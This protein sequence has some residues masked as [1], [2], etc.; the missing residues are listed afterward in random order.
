VGLLDRT[1]TLL[2]QIGK[3]RMGR[4]RHAR[5]ELRRCL[6]EAMESRQLLSAAP[7]VVGAVYIEEDLGS[8]AHGDTFQLTFEGGA[9]GTELARLTISTDQ[10]TPGFSIGDVFFDTDTGSLGADDSFPFMLLTLETADP[11]ASVSATVADGGLELVL[12]FNGFRAGDRLTFQIDVDEVEYLDAAETDLELVNEGFDPITSGIEFQGSLMRAEFTAEHYYEVQAEGQFWNRY[13]DRFAGS[14]LQLPSDDANG[15]RDRSTGAIGTAQQQPLPISLAGTVYLDNDL[16]LVQGSGEMGLSGVTLELWQLQGERYQPTGETTVTDAEG[17]YRFGPELGL[18]PGTYQ[19]REVQPEGLFSVGASPGQVLGE[20]VGSVVVGQPDVLTEIHLPLGDLHA[21][22]LDFAEADPAEVS[23]WVYHDR[24]NNGL[25]DDGEEGISG[26]SLQIEPLDTIAAQA[27][28][29]VVTDAGGAYAATGLAPGEYRVVEIEQPQGFL[30]GLDAAGTVRGLVVGAAVNPGDAIHD[31]TLRGGDRGVEY[32]FGELVPASISG[33]VRLADRDGD[34][35]GDDDQTLPLADVRIQL[36]EMSDRLVAETVTDTLG[37]YRFAGLR[38][39]IYRVVEFTPEGLI[40]GAEH[41]GTVDGVAVGVAS[42]DGV[43]EDI[44]LHS[45]DRGVD[46]DFCEL[47]PASL[48]GHVYHD[49]NDD[50]LRG[51]GEEGLSGAVVQLL[52]DQGGIVATQLTDEAGYYEFTDLHAGVYDVSELQPDGW[53][54]GQDHAGTVNG[55]P[56][57]EV[58]IDGDRIDRVWLRWG[59]EAEDYDFGELQMASISGNV[60]LSTPAGDCYGPDG[61]LPPLSGVQVDL[62]NEQGALLRTEYTNEDGDY[63]FPDLRPGNYTIVE[64][65]PAEVI[66]GAELIGTIDGVTVGQVTGNDRIGEIVITSGQHALDYDFCEHAPASLAGFVY[67]DRDNDGR[68]ES[69]DPPIA[70]VVVQLWDDQGHLVAETLTDGAGEF[71]FAGLAAGAYTLREIQPEGYRD[72]TDSAGRVGTQTVGSAENPGDAIDGILLQWGDDGVDYA[73]AEWISSSIEGFV[74]EDRDQDCQ[75]DADEAAI[76]NVLIELFDDQGQRLA[77]TR[78]DADGHY[79]FDD[80]APGTYALAERQPD[81]Y[82]HGCQ[83]AGTGG[84]EDALEDA[85][86]DILMLSGER[87]REYNFGEIPPVSLSGYVFQDGAPLVSSDGRL[88]ANARTLRDGLRTDDDLPIAGVTIE[89]RDGTTGQPLSRAMVLPGSYGPGPIQAITDSEGHYAFS[90]LRPGNYAVFEVQPAGFFDGNDT[91][92]TFAAYAFNDEASL[93]SPA[94]AQLMVDHHF[95]AIVGIRIPVGERSQENNFSEI[96]L[97]IQTPRVPPP[98]PPEPARLPDPL[99]RDFVPPPPKAP[100]LT[101]VL[102]KPAYFRLVGVGGAIEF[103]WHLSV[104]DAGTPRGPAQTAVRPSVWRLT[105]FLEPADWHTRPMDQGRWLLRHGLGD[106]ARVA[107]YQFGTED[108]LPIVA[109][110]NGDGFDELGIYLEGLWYVDLNGNGVWDDEDLWALL[111]TE[112]DLPVTG[113]WNGDGKDDI[114][115]FGPAWEG[116]PRALS[117]ES[118]LPDLRNQR[119]DTEK[120]KNV[121]PEPDEATN[122]ARVLRHTP[123]GSAR[124]D[125]ID[126]VFQYGGGEEIPVSGDWSGDGIKNIGIFHNGSWR[127]DIDGDGRWSEGDRQVEFGKAADLPVVGDFNG[128]GIDDLAVFRDG[129]WIVDINGNG[130]FD[131]H[132]LVFAHGQP[133]DLPIAGDWNADGTDD[134]GVYRQP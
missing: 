131:A 34:C 98:D 7:L 71:A 84:G 29:T 95:D 74:Y 108:G 132:D 5:G 32:N 75:R 55:V 88:P 10:N 91:L 60:H 61:T 77:E 94:A 85:I 46:Y 27:V 53:I 133:G 122:R 1:R 12:D 51:T 37:R 76:A 107:E 58:A 96:R 47:K 101:P 57:G 8:D 119:E 124:A 45:A 38:P 41:P 127:L 42:G 40:D 50:G 66:D 54:D 125:V 4:Q 20:P 24:N 89:L 78:T 39:G 59:D 44:A 35:Y 18:Q 112:F 110:W 49:R 116:D 14:S 19:V 100:W 17:R 87:L 52:D 126:H 67:H 48:S 25:R 72:G 63:H 65:T 113:D 6:F 93:D 134:P 2:R 68:R 26:V 16:N 118:G 128:D 120:P 15:K 28:V 104:I 102:Q 22:Q 83:Q 109:D 81:G 130:E 56:V 115:I 82:F 92:G 73:F 90:G 123:E 80:L 99:P 69:G 62:L 106:D 111:G 13:D 97:N 33:T 117:V 3:R 64:H 121:P 30:D 36:W 11:Q 105:G 9:A 86:S 31:L 70:D 23:G 79:R 114:G 129:T 103:S 43:I 21:V